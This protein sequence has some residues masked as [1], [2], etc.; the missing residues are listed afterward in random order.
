L[1]KIFDS[2]FDEIILESMEKDTINKYLNSLKE[3][4]IELYEFRKGTYIG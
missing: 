2:G 3:I 1:E 4:S